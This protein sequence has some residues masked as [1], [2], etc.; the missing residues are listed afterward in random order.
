[1][2]PVFGFWFSFSHWNINKACTQLK[3]NSGNGYLQVKLAPCLLLDAYKGTWDHWDTFSF[4][5]KTLYWYF[6][7]FPLS[8]W[9][10]KI[11]GHYSK[12]NTHRMNHSVPVEVPLVLCFLFEADL[13]GGT[14][15]TLMIY[16]FWAAISMIL[17]GF[18]GTY[19]C[20]TATIDS[21]VR[22]FS[23]L[24]LTTNLL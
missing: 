10:V 22:L 19:V 5:K 17:D 4:G 7:T 23:S 3:I 14:P 18:W 8:M 6:S 9:L 15:Q 12:F 20:E 24:S 16:H 11:L 2:R 21:K 13:E 1:M